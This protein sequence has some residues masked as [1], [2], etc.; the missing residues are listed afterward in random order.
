MML[1]FVKTLAANEVCEV[2][3]TGQY[4]ELRAAADLVT[5]VE[6]LDKS[7]GVVSLLQ[8]VEATDYVRT[9]R[10]FETVRITNGATPQALRFYY[11]DGDSGSNRFTG[12]VS[13]EVSLNAATLAALEFLDLNAATLATL[14]TPLA[15]TASVFSTGAAVANTPFTMIAPAA[16]VNG[17][18][19]QELHAFDIG[20]SAA[21]AGGFYG[22]T[23]APGTVFS[24]GALPV[25]LLGLIAVNA[26]AIYHRA[27]R[28]EEFLLPAGYGLYYIQ[29]F[30]GDASSVRSATHRTL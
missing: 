2:A 9:D 27:E 14:R 7:G 13:G 28:H 29:N 20:A 8:D 23:V 5:R 1:P 22:A 25:A 19:L 12:V 30:A 11:G 4:L 15:P 18:I 24:P 21:N 10:R 16:N 6:L 26:S 3:L 17:I